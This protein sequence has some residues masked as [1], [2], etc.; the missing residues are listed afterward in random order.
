MRRYYLGGIAAG[1]LLV[2][3]GPAQAVVLRYEPKV[4]SAYRYKQSLAGRMETSMAGVDQTMRM[5]FTGELNY[6]EKILS[7][8]D[9]VSRVERELLG[10]QGEIKLDG[11]GETFDMPRGTVTAEVDRLGRIVRVQEGE[12][13]GDE[14]MPPIMGPS[15]ESMANWSQFSA[16]P[17]GEI[18]SG[19]SWSG[20]LA[21]PL[22][23]EGPEIEVRYS[24]ELLA[25]TTF[26]DRKCAKLRTSFTAPFN[27]DAGELLGAGGEQGE[28]GVEADLKGDLLWYYDYENSVYVYTE[29]TVGADMRMNVPGMPG[30]A[31]TKMIINIKDVMVQ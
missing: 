4:G 27:V 20:K 15:A 12:F 17:E 1:L 18:Q 31:A 25:V 11:D 24:S 19:D 16:F 30:E 8:T 26:Q 2:A 13:E 29:G 14:G 3:H 22:T 5:E 21:L 7:Q 23:S 9:Q 10:G 6:S 28:G